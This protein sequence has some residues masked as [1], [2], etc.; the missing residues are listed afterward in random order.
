MKPRTNLN[1]A[2]PSLRDG[3]QIVVQVAAV[4]GVEELVLVDAVR[5]ICVVAVDG[6]DVASGHGNS[7]L[8]AGHCFHI[9]IELLERTHAAPEVRREEESMKR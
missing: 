7:V 6:M 1:Q 3:D 2:V 8:E 9:C 5:L 4:D